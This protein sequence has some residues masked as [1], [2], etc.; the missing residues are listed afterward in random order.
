[1]HHSDISC[2]PRD[3]SGPWKASDWPRPLNDSRL[4]LRY[5]EHGAQVVSATA[6]FGEASKEA[7]PYVRRS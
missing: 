5:R 2:V 3:S 6:G 4:V 7:D 1:M